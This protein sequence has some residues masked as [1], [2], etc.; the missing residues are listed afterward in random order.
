M[1][2]CT[3]IE[4]AYICLN[5]FDRNMCVGISLIKEAQSSIVE[6]QKIDLSDALSKEK[7]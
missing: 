1:Q 6:T 4:K 5:V 7:F 3:L 2:K